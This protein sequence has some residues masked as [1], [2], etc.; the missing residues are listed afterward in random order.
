MLVHA[1][2]LI[3]VQL[4]APQRLCALKDPSANCGDDIV[5]DVPVSGLKCTGSIQA[6]KAGRGRFLRVSM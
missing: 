3:V 5:R 6:G 1:S 4:Q 2:D